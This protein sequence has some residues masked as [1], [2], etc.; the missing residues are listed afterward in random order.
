MAPVD[1][2]ASSTMYPLGKDVFAS[3]RTWKGIVKIHVRHY[4]APING[5]EGRRLPTQKGVAMDAQQFQNLLRVHKKLTTDYRRQTENLDLPYMRFEIYGGQEPESS[6]QSDTRKGGGKAVCRWLSASNN[7]PPA[8]VVVVVVKV[9]DMSPLVTLLLV[10]L[11]SS[12]SASLAVDPAD[13]QGASS[14]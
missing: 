5:K 11:V 12:A 1:Q 14:G 10:S 8:A 3:V 2:N 4:T 7:Q 9:S 13:S 6:C